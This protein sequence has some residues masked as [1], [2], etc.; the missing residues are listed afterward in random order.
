M[1]S[2]PHST[3]ICALRYEGWGGERPLSFFL[4]HMGPYI[5][6][7]YRHGH[8][9]MKDGRV[10]QNTLH[11]INMAIWTAV[12]QC[13]DVLT[14][15]NT[16]MYSEIYHPSSPPLLTSGAIWY[17]E[18]RVIP[19]HE[20]SMYVQS[21]LGWCNGY[22]VLILSHTPIYLRPKICQGSPSLLLTS[23][24]IYGLWRWDLEH[25]NW[26]SDPKLFS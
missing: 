25:K 14:A 23:E 5:V 21:C 16:H 15:M 24:A 19:L 11:G 20:L 2:L 1:L 8:G 18:A 12:R 26:L 9:I 3:P 13:Y 4:G 22:T 10:V 6:H 7:G 17:V